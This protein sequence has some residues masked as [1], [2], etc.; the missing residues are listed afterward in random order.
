[1]CNLVTISYH[2]VIENN[3]ISDNNIISSVNYIRYREVIN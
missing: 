3:F 2:L 1:M